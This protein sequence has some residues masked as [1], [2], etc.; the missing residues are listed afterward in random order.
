M[1]QMGTDIGKHVHGRRDGTK[2]RQCAAILIR[3]DP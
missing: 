2:A 1:A 3:V